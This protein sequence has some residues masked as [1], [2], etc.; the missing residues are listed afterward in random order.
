MSSSQGVGI[1]PAHDL[2]RAAVPADRRAD[3]L[4]PRTGARPDRPAGAQSAR[5]PVKPKSSQAGGQGRPSPVP[6][7]KL[8]RTLK[9]IPVP[10]D[11]PMF[12]VQMVNASLL[13]RD[14]EGIWVLDF[15]FKPLRI[16]TVDIPGKGRRQVH[17]L[18]YKVVNRTGKP[19]MFVPQFIMVNEKRAEVR[20]Q[21]RPRGHPA[22][23]AARGADD[24]APG[25]GEHH[26]NDPAEHQAERR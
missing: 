26:G 9:T 12:N 10:H 2:K 15:A 19:R 22:H 7:F 4:P 24:P 18:Y 21:R 3:R 14:K 25:G 16:K 1:P 20:G 23:P 17:Y 6:E 8:D 13:P 5:R 11:R